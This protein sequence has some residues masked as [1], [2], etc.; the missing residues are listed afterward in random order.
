LN[1]LRPNQIPEHF[2][3]HIDFF[4]MIESLWR[5][6]VIIILIT[7]V[8]ALLGGLIAFN[9]PATYRATVR[10]LPPSLSGIAELS[11][12]GDFASTA[13]LKLSMEDLQSRTFA[14]FLQ[15]LTSSMIRQEF[16]RDNELRAAL[17]K[18]TVSMQEGFNA[19]AGLV[20][21]KESKKGSV[22][23]TFDARDPNLAANSANKFVELAIVAF[24]SQANESFNAL[25][26][27]D[28]RVLQSELESLINSH[29]ERIDAE[30]KKLSEALRIT[31]SLNISDPML[32]NNVTFRFSAQSSPIVTDD[33]PPIVTEELRYLYSQGSRA[34]E[35][36]IEAVGNRKGKLVLVSGAAEKK[37]KLDALTSKSFDPLAVMPVTI[38]MP[39]V[40]PETRLKPR[41]SLIIILSCIV[42]SILAV[43]F[44]LLRNAVH[45]RKVVP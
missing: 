17:F 38:D 1:S 16:L 4:E 35:A 21:V 40:P 10:M 37:R 45:A 14:Q 20:E 25:K 27:Q 9:T 13:N 34:L 41:R 8:A 3:D 12:L 7:A 42:G 23:L 31:K 28:R 15:K 6:K 32:K 33:T 29:D 19:L 44:V 39:A 18:R 2:N 11:K 24:R 22:T 30:Q 5:A 36:E 26:N 43:V